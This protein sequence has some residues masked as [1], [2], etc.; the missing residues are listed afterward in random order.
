MLLE[1][2]LNSKQFSSISGATPIGSAVAPLIAQDNRTIESQRLFNFIHKLITTAVAKHS[3][4][5][6]RPP[7]I[8]LGCSTQS[9]KIRPADSSS[10]PGLA[11]AAFTL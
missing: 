1:I 8:L 6:M 11:P 7:H 10:R 3:I 2:K 4:P 5:E 9:A